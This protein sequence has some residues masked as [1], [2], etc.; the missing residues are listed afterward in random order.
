[1]FHMRI[2]NDLYRL[3]INDRLSFITVARKYGSPN[4]KPDHAAEFLGR[5]FKFFRKNLNVLDDVRSY[6]FKSFIESM[7]E[8]DKLPFLENEREHVLIDNF[9]SFYFRTLYIFKNSRHIFDM[10]KN[11]ERELNLLRK[12]GDG[13]HVNNY[14][15]VDSMEEPA[16]QLS[17]VVSGLLG[18]L[19]T[20]IRNSEFDSLSIIKKNLNYFGSENRDLLTTLIDKSD[21]IS[22]G[23]FCM[24]ASEEECQKRDYFLHDLHGT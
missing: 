5:L 13:R 22:N 18:K 19:F 15:F 17:D 16:I 4:I 20:F 23:F 24:L 7:E 14:F 11:V 10:E 21:N 9:S 3:V 6:L 1:M 8:V 2:K 12:R